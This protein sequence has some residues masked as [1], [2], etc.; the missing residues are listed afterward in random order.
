MLLKFSL[1]DKKLNDLHCK[2]ACNKL[3]GFLQEWNCVN[4]IIGM[5]FDTTSFIAKFS[6]M[7]GNRCTILCRSVTNYTVVKNLL[8]KST[9][10]LFFLYL[11]KY[12]VATLPWNLEFDNLGKK[13]TWKTWNLRNFE[14][15]IE[16]DRNFE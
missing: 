11:T 16:K 4:S 15:C 1:L 12:R 13:E 10:L 5:V 3:F 9:L 7:R 2:T 6:F 8:K 14:N